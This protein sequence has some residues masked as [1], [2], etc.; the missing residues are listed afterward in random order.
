LETENGVPENITEF[1]TIVGA[2]FAE[3]YPVFPV[4]K[5]LDP[6]GVLGVFGPSNGA[7]LERRVEVFGHTVR[8]LLNEGYIWSSTLGWHPPSLLVLT[9]K[10]LRVMNAVPEGVSRSR[11]SQTGRNSESRFR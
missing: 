7:V 1:N 8:W 10:G 4:S 9:E 11:G 6:Y 5:P 2:V 3:L